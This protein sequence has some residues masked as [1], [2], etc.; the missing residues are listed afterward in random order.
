M[1]TLEK[2]TN[3]LPTI[4]AKPTLQGTQGTA[5]SRK[6]ILRNGFITVIVVILMLCQAEAVC[7][8]LVALAKPSES[9]V[10]EFD[11]KL[12]IARAKPANGLPEVLFLGDSYTSR[13]VYPELL[14]N[15][16]KEQGLPIEARNLASTSNTSQMS[17]F[18]LQTAIK[19][20]WKPKVVVY[21]LSPRLFNHHYLEH[22]EDT[23]QA[24]FEDSYVGRCQ[25]HKPQG[26]NR[27][28]CQLEKSLYLVRYRKYWAEQLKQFPDIMNHPDRYLHDGGVGKAVH[29]ISPGGWS[30]GY[31]IYTPADYTNKMAIDGKDGP[32]N[33]KTAE[34]L[35]GQYQWDEQKFRE[36]QA[37]CEKSNIPLLLVWYPEN[38]VR[39]P[40]YRYYHLSQK[41]FSARFATLTHPGKS[42]FIDFHNADTDPRHFYNTD[43][44]NVLGAIK[45]TEKIAHILSQEPFRSQLHPTQSA[46][47][48]ETHHP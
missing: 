20:G 10:R 34:K 15:Q 27:W 28:Q 40:Y 3:D 18:F 23:S 30:P 7:R 45:M 41:T 12:A 44:L 32:Y 21:G 4:A 14:M 13:A 17:L 31:L 25:F 36:L 6:L 11:H 48:T 26:L 43:H 42:W 38:L 29:E 37:Y 8:L 5:I 22:G 9:H 46:Q 1:K 39:E 2:D 35:F 33:I 19:A 24:Q 16:L 47:G